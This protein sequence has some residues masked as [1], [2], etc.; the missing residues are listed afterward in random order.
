LLEQARVESGELVLEID[1]IDLEEV[2]Q[3]IVSSFQPQAA[4]HGVNLELRALRPIIV[5]ADEHRLSQV[6]VNLIDN[7]LRYTP[8]GGS[9]DVTIDV[10]DG[11]AVIQV[12]DTGIG[13]PYKDL[14]Y[15][16][17]RFYVVD[18]SRARGIS[19][20]GLGL[21]IVKHIV[22]AHGGN[23]QVESTLGTGTTFT[24]R[25]PMVSAQA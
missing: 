10:D 15:V 6:F 21:S 14:P 18:R 12:R 11:Y 20:A 9:V 7:A 24:V 8:D 1:E 22:E 17:E 13:I 16:F 4:A 3:P 25:V 19:G 5:E 2:A 23:V